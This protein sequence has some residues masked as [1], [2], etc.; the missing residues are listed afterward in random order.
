MIPTSLGASTAAS[1]SRCGRSR[2]IA[3]HVRLLVEYRLAR[4]HN[5]AGYLQVCL[6]DRR[7]GVLGE[8]DD[9][10]TPCSETGGHES[11]RR[12]VA[13]DLQDLH[14]ASD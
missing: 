8:A 1:S 12:D 11:L 6:A 4:R 9:A 3:R 5:P 10:A 13:E 2:H 14:K 7:S